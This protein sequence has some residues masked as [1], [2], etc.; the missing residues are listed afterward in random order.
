[1]QAYTV[2]MQLSAFGFTVGGE[3]TWGQYQGTVSAGPTRANQDDSSHFALGVTYTTGAISLGAFY[4][5]AEQDS[6]A[7]STQKREQTVWGISGLYAIAPGLD[8]YATY[9]QLQD[10]NVNIALSGRTTL[11]NR[12]A[13]VFLIGTRIAF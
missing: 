11:Q 12:E 5:S 8:V 4:G 9:A 6:N 2:G 1:M 7:S 10:D 3:Y 13:T